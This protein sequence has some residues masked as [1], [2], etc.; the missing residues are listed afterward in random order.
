MLEGHHQA[1]SNGIIATIDALVKIRRYSCEV[2]PDQGK[3]AQ[4]VI[5]HV[6]SFDFAD[7]LKDLFVG[8][9]EDE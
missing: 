7:A 8:N 4:K 3:N 1:A 5:A 6:L 2:I 9:L